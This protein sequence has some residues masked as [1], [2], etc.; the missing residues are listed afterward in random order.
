[1]ALWSYQ[2]AV[3]CSCVK[4]NLHIFLTF[5]ACT[6]HDQALNS[7]FITPSEIRDCGQH[8]RILLCPSQPREI[9]GKGRW[10]HVSLHQLLRGSRFWIATQE[11]R[12]TRSCGGRRSTMWQKQCYRKE[13]CFITYY[14]LL[15]HIKGACNADVPNLLSI[16]H[17]LLFLYAI[18]AYQPR[19]FLFRRVWREVRTS[20]SL[21]PADFLF[22]T[23]QG[24]KYH[25]YEYWG[26]CFRCKR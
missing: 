20:R 1:M 13:I 9:V 26:R 14:L 3:L 24:L 19:C 12:T 10:V 11:S 21:H 8:K 6:N 25:P 23:P 18:R 7:L 16:I 17:N 4:G 5:F 2:A 22:L 15:E